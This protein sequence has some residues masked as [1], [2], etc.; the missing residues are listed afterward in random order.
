MRDVMKKN[1]LFALIVIQPILDIIAYLQY[2]SKIGTMAGYIRLA[3]MCIIVCYAW[4][5]NIKNVKYYVLIGI[6]GIYCL[7]HIINGFRVGYLNLIEDVSY[8]AK[9]VQMPLLAISFCFILK[10]SFIKCK[11]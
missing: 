8:M 6:V 3:F 7:L 2:D 10:D 1:W 4:V 9:V 11:L 5:K